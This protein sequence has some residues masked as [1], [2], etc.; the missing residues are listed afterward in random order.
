MRG[1]SG[2]LHARAGLSDVA[3]TTFDTPRGSVL[4]STVEATAVDLVG[5]MG[6]AG[7]VDRVAGMLGV[8]AEQMD[9]GLLVD[10]A[11]SVSVRWAQ[12]LGYLLEFIDAGDR[13]GPLKDHVRQH[14]RN[15]TRLLPSAPASGRGPRV[16]M[17]TVRQRARRAG[18]VIPRDYVTAWRA[19][20]PW[21]EDAQVEQ[22][23]VISRALVEMFSHPLLAR[24]LAFRGGTALYK[25]YLTPPARYSEDIDLV[26]VTAGPAGAVMDAIQA[27]LNPWLGKPGWRQTQGRVTFRYG[28]ASGGAPPMPMRLKVE[29]N[30]REHVAVLGH[31]ERR[32]SV[33]SRSFD[34]TGSI[35]TFELDDAG[36]AVARRTSARGARPLRPDAGSRRRP[37]IQ[38]ALC[39][40]SA[41]TWPGEAS[42]LPRDALRISTA[43]S[44]T[45]DSVR[46]ERPAC[47]WA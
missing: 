9:P 22:D 31:A 28:F 27:T 20:A 32:L 43:S 8:L 11:R 30:T 21:V 45:R 26:H 46:H 16:R 15:Y 14:A 3:L 2:G 5:Y 41:P 29:I 35:R 40:R 34:R 4:A 23:L 12:R 25:L 24:S 36:D 42:T 18:S 47:G 44:A 19:S 33:R 13:C 39:R 7:G 1:G 10:A 17:A 37:L 6:R 38:S